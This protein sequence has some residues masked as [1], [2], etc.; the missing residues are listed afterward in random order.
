MKFLSL[1]NKALYDL[2]TVY[3]PLNFCTCVFVVIHLLFCNSL[4]FIIAN[5]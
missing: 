2:I 5:N 1:I 3:L 4:V